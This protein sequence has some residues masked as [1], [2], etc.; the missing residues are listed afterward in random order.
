MYDF[1]AGISFIED[2]LQIPQLKSAWLAG[3]QEHRSLSDEDI[4]MIDTMVM[5]R[6][7]LLLAWVGSHK[8]ADIVADLETDFGRITTMLAERYLSDAANSI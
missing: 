8:D 2:D 5:L 4:Q 1:A 3:Y 7:M 6:R